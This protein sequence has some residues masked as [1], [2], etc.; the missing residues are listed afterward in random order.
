[1]KK[2]YLIL[3]VSLY[4]PIVIF[5]N[6]VYDD[7]F[8]FKIKLYN[9]LDLNASKKFLAEYKQTIETQSLTPEESLTL[10][11][12]FVLEEINF[13][14]NEQGVPESKK[15]YKL[16]VKQNKATEGFIN[17]KKK[18]DVNSW[19]LLSWADLKSRLTVFLSGQNLYK[20]ALISKELYQFVLKKDKNF[21]PAHIAYGLCLFFAPPI[22]GGG[23]DV[24]LK[25]FTN[26]VSSAKNENEKYYALCCRSQVYL[27]LEQPKDCAADLEQA[28]ALIADENFTKI[29]SEQNKNDKLFF[30]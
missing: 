4:L 7:F 10:K 29:I 14:K 21:S 3:L 5:A 11:N 19:L 1:M 17:G 30:E 23:Y 20:E 26:A 12:L 27:A 22:S 2:L 9:Q 6:S 15:I 25:E 28:H 18:S 13:L 24:A 8:E 16:L